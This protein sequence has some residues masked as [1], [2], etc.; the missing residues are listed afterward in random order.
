MH[1][2]QGQDGCTYGGRYKTRLHMKSKRS[3]NETMQS[4]HLNHE[5]RD[6]PHKER[7]RTPGK[8]NIQKTP[9]NDRGIVCSRKG[10]ESLNKQ[11]Q[12]IPNDDAVYAPQPQTVR[13]STYGRVHK[14]FLTQ[15]PKT[16]RNDAIYAPQ[17]QEARPS[18]Q[19]NLLSPHTHTIHTSSM[20]RCKPRTSATDSAVVRARKLAIM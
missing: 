7:H 20:K 6:C 11:I 18:V 16:S 15:N 2:S 3:P 8:T 10:T 1:L 17:P 19:G 12:K 14:P 5:P 13:P 4:T 9:N